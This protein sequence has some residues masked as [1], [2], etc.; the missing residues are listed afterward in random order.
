MCVTAGG[1]RSG[2]A[3]AQSISHDRP[4]KV[5]SVCLQQMMCSDLGASRLKPLALALALARKDGTRRPDV[6]RARVAAAA[7]S[8]QMSATRALADRRCHGA[9]TCGVL[10]LQ[11]AHRHAAACWLIMEQ[12]M[13]IC[14]PPCIIALDAHQLIDVRGC[15]CALADTKSKV[16][17]MGH[18]GLG[19]GPRP[20]GDAPERRRRRWRHEL[21]A[22]RNLPR[23]WL[24][25]RRHPARCAR[26]QAS[27]RSH[28]CKGGR[29]AC[30]LPP[31]SPLPRPNPAAVARRLD[32]ASARRRPR[33]PQCARAT[34]CVPTSPRSLSRPTARP[35]SPAAPAGPR[36]HAGCSAA[37]Q[38]A[39][40]PLAPS[41]VAPPPPSA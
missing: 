17:H 24:S 20:A 25:R 27:Q 8:A 5:D 30:P 2:A 3:A 33:R 21:S 29:P 6:G 37:H 40:A 1:R 9:C 14:A 11:C 35:P 4:P 18:R 7:A 13:S 15:G 38:P 26:S 41:T 12:S 22:T 31:S 23:T 39:A 16:R 32:P 36:K 34:E 10:L 19:W 28:A